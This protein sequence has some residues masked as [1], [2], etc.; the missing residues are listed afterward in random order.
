MEACVAV[1]DAFCAN[2][3]ECCEMDPECEP[4]VDLAHLGATASDCTD[5]IG[6]NECPAIEALSENENVGFDQAA[7]EA[8]AQ[9][10]E[11]ATCMSLGAASG[12]LLALCSSPIFNPS[13]DAGDPCEIP[14]ECISGSCESNGLCAATPPTEES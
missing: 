7:L 8:C 10:V 14:Q 1:A 11:Q 3:F 13:Q 9:D 4:S 2:V 6:A 5:D 12:D